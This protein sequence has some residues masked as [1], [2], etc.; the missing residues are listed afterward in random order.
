MGSPGR[1]GA[2]VEKVVDVGL[3]SVRQRIDAGRGHPA[4]RLLHPDVICPRAVRF[5]ERAVA[6]EQRLDFVPG[7]SVGFN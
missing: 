6:I 7:H 5:I 2:D 1:T 4:G 3:H